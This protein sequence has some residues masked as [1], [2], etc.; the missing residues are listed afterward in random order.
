M[1]QTQYIKTLVQTADKNIDATLKLLSEDCTIPFIAR[2][3]K[4]Q[5]GNL[6]EVVIEDIAKLAKQFDEIVKRKA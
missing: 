4:D 5:T 1:T 3:R 6:N 2:Y